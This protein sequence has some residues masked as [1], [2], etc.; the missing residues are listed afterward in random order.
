MLKG[1]ATWVNSSPK[2][3]RIACFCFVMIVPKEEVRNTHITCTMDHQLGLGY[4]QLFF[5][6]AP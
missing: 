5:G 2:A 4:L 3:Q 6:A 1:T